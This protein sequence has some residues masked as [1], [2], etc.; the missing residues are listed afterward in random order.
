MSKVF[1][2]YPWCHTLMKF[3]VISFSTMV[4]LDTFCM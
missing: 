4:L 2:D 1:N 3:N